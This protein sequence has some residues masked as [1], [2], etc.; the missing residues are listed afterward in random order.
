MKLLDGRET[1]NLILNEI[2][3]EISKL[4]NKPGLG[5][6]LVGNRSDSKIYVKMK[7]RACNKVGIQNYDVLLDENISEEILIEEIF[8]NCCNN[9]YS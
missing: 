3:N 8:G 4:N 2:K 7:K 1:S 9:A 6:I 5:I